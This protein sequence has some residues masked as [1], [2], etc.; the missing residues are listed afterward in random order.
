[1]ARK[2]RNRSSRSPHRT[3]TRRPRG[4]PA[5]PDD[6]LATLTDSDLVQGLRKALRAA[7]PTVFPV[8]ASP[9]V[10]LMGQ[11]G[12][13]LVD[14]LPEGVDLLQSFCEVDIAETTALLHVYATLTS[15]DLGRTRARQTLATRRQPMPGHVRTMDQLAVSGTMLMGTDPAGDNFLVGLR[16]PEGTEATMVVYV[17]REPEAWVKDA[18][19]VGDGLAATVAHFAQLVAG[20]GL[21]P[22]YG[23]QPVDPAEVRAA[24]DQGLA[25]AARLPLA[26][27]DDPDEVQQWPMCRVLVEHVVSL[28]PSGGRGYDETGLLPEQVLDD[29][30]AWLERDALDPDDEFD[31]DDEAELEDEIEA[32]TQEFLASAQARGLP[33]D[34]V[35][36]LAVLTLLRLAVAAEGDPLHW[37]PHVL[38]WVLLEALPQDWELDDPTLD[39]ALQ[40]LPGLVA[41]AGEV[42]DEEP[43]HMALV[44]ELIPDWTAQLRELRNDPDLVRAR[45]WVAAASAVVDGDLSAVLQIVLSERVGG[46]EELAALDATPLPDEPLQVERL[47]DDVRD[48]A[49]EVDEA[50]VAGLDRLDDHHLDHEFRTACRRFLRTAVENDPGV[51][52]NRAKADNTAAAIAWTVGRANDLVGYSPAPVR[53]GDLMAAFGRTSPPSSRADRLLTAFGVPHALVGVSLGSPALLVSRARAEIVRQRDEL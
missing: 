10:E 23:P 15:D 5:S 49:R 28:L 41:W 18:F 16:W 25:A 32:H 42:T 3:A 17:P 38:E 14:V 36:E 12:H 27:Q 1:M 50:L 37:C 20:D 26:E 11:A 40:A 47:P 2:H 7:D 53:T 39:R 44:Q 52:R 51:L 4:A 9:L 29:P 31:L 35:T 22:D 33:A 45:G 21:P 43:E 19:F 13:E 34:E 46:T 24:L 30:F 48:R 6:R 8:T